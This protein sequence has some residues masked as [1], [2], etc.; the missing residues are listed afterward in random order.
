MLKDIYLRFLEENHVEFYNCNYKTKKL[1][2]KL[3]FNSF[4]N[5][6]TKANFCVGQIFQ[7]DE[8]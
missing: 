2:E 5:L 1:K 7:E 4:G 3:K 6:I 8:L